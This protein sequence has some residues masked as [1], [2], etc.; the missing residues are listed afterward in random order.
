MLAKTSGAHNFNGH[1]RI[2]DW[3]T[4]H[5]RVLNALEMLQQRGN[6]DRFLSH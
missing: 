4:T 5:V 6:N 2:Q 1:A 3:Q